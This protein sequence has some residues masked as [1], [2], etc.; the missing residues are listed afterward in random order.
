MPNPSWP[1]GRTTPA[2]TYFPTLPNEPKTPLTFRVDAQ[3]LAEIALV[4]RTLNLNLSD[5]CRLLLREATTARATKG[6]T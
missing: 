3:L 6:R 4:G 2:R 1:P 5:T